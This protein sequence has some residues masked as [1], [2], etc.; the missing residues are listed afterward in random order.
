MNVPYLWMYIILIPLLMVDGIYCGNIDLL[1]KSRWYTQLPRWSRH[2]LID[3]IYLFSIAVWQIFKLYPLNLPP[4]IST[5]SI[6]WGVW[7]LPL[8][9]SLNLSLSRAIRE[10]KKEL[11]NYE[12]KDKSSSE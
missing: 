7:G 8:V 6:L 11:R 10:A 5:F 4:K 1:E 2:L 9:V 12:Q 3:F